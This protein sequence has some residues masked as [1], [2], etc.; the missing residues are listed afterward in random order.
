MTMDTEIIYRIANWNLERPLK[1]SKKLDLA[2]QKIQ[3]I[4][5][6]ICILTETSNLVDLGNSYCASKTD[7]YEDFPN[8]QWATIW[9]KYPIT[10]EIQTFDSC[11]A[12]C[13][14]I[15]APFG[16]IIVYATIIPY[17]NSGVRDGGQYLYA[18]RTYK[19][20]EMHKEDIQHQGQDWLRISAEYPDI[21][22][23]IAGDFNQ[24][25]D[26]QKR[27]YGTIDGRNL[28]TVAL[29]NSN[30]VCITDED[31]AGHGKLQPNPKTGVT[32]RNIDHICLSINWFNSLNNKYIGAWDHFTEEGVF[33]TDHNGVYFDFAI[34]PTLT[35]KKVPTPK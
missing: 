32:R 26:E 6:D 31:F 29:N 19:A 30:L 3:T 8:E 22:L 13:A 11:K 27:G 33:M 2:L 35:H 7:E 20:W 1:Q 10:E 24:T 16:K 9:S 12:T 23:C 14:L 17:H 5:P 28:L 4:N 25:R 15:Q 21:P 18:P 34:D